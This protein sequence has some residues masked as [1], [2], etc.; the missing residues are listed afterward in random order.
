[1]T[2]AALTATALVLTACGRSD[3]GTTVETA[4]AI[5]GSPAT[6]EITIWAAE[7]EGRALSAT[8]EEFQAANPDVTITVTPVSFD[9]LPRKVDTAIASGEVPDI[10]QPSTGLQS[11]VSAGGIAPVPDG[12]TD[13]SDFFDS[14]V[15]AVTFD[16]VLY[17]VPW[18]VTVQS[19]YYRADLAEEA[20]LDAPTTWE[21]NLEFGAALREDG[22]DSGTF[23]APSGTLAW[24]TILPMIYQAGG[25]VIDD[26]EFTLDTPEVV[27]ALGHYQ[28]FFAQ[29]I[30]DVQ[31]VI[32]AAGEIEAA[33]A[34]GSIGS[35]MT[36]SY[37]YDFA[38]DALG[39]DASKLGLAP[40]PEGPVNGMGYIGGSG[41]AVMADSDNQESAWKFVRHATSPENAVAAYEVSG[42]LPAN[43][44]A[45]ESGALAESPTAETF[46]TQ[47]ENSVPLPQVLTWTQIRDL[48]ATYG[49]QLAR[50]V[51]TPEEAA[52]EMQREAEAIGTGE[53]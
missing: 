50:E 23:V 44:A 3:A 53:Q 36:G 46:A 32:T 13:T 33:F 45:W 8:A 11:Y 49:E 48:L 26:G 6:G 17:A 18:Y 21:E 16:D 12:V 4:E 41:L 52:A 19:F 43:Q 29:D 24:Q 25:S 47:L 10:I 22:A 35:Y 5:D 42:V 7:N 27:E 15:S 51:I 9:E 38:L 28:E 2:T 14:A 37:S 31:K 1:M 39:G 20:G 30:S 34:D 40:L